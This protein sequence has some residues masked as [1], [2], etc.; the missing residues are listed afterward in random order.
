MPSC[1]HCSKECGTETATTY[2]SSLKAPVHNAC[3]KAWMADSKKACQAVDRDCN[4]CRHF[5]RGAWLSKAIC[6]GKCAKDG[7]DTL[8][9]PN[10]FTDRKCWENR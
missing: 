8:A 5:V 7:S 4:D 9:Y 10:A 1:L 3:R 6:S 2:W